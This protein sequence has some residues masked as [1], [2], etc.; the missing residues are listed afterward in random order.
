MRPLHL[1]EISEVVAIDIDDNP[2]F[3]PQRRLPDPRDVIEICSSLITMTCRSSDDA[4]LDPDCA[5]ISE[6]RR[7]FVTLAHFSVKE[8]LISDI[9]RLGETV[10]YS[11]Q[12]IDCHSSLAKDCLAYLLHFDEV[13]SLTS[14]V[15]TNYPLADYAAQNWTKHARMARSIDNT[16]SQDFLLTKGNAF[17]NWIR[18]YDSE[19]PFGSDLTRPPGEI[20]SPLYYASGARLLESVKMLLDSGADINALGG[21]HGTALNA[22]SSRGYV[23]IVHL[24]LE[25]GAHMHTTSSYGTALEA[26][27]SSGRIEIVQLLLDKGVH[28]KSPIS[29]GTALQKFSSSGDIEA[30]QSLLEKIADINVQAEGY[31]ALIAVLFSGHVEIV[32]LPPWRDFHTDITSFFYDTALQAASW[33]GHHRIVQILVEKGAGINARR[34]FWPNSAFLPATGDDSDEHGQLLIENRVNFTRMEGELGKLESALSLI[35]ISKR[36]RLGQG[37]VDTQGRALCHDASAQNDMTRLRNLLQTGSDLTVTDKQ[38]RTCLH[39]A[40]IGSRKGPGAVSWLLEVG[41]NPNLPDRDG[42]TPLHWAAKVGDSKT[43]EILEDF[44]AKFSLENIM[45][46]TPDDVAVFH[47]QKISWKVVTSLGYK[48]RIC[49]GKFREYSRCCGCHFVSYP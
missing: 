7:S 30:V 39:H 38:G 49:P 33:S 21:F 1:E 14:G 28:V 37:L 43:I 17:F 23:E 45:G 9:I 16:L 8:Y 34:K 11:L 44:G 10:K 2:R 5:G 31:G 48:S 12:E 18:L 20:A 3:D 27:S 36:G 42:W 46:W 4:E 24:L 40:A 13:S 22:A 32:R 26:A 47:H 25:R 15:F 35:E 19:R 41:F 6:V 29:Y